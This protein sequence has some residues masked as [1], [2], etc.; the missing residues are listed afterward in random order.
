MVA[1]PETNAGFL[2]N[3]TFVQARKFMA[4]AA[5]SGGAGSGSRSFRN[6][7][8]IKSKGHERIDIV[9][10]SGYCIRSTEMN[11]SEALRRLNEI[12]QVDPDPTLDVG[13]LEAMELVADNTE[14][15]HLLVHRYSRS[16]SANIAGY[17]ALLLSL[18]SSSITPESAPLVFE[19]ADKLKRKDHDAALMKIARR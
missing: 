9:V 3:P 17:L 13:A 4:R 15:L 8:V 7:E 5:A 11:K 6:A 19:F 16:S 18:K 10:N 14:G 2:R 12:E 1:I